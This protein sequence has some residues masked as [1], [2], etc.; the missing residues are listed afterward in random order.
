VAL[1]KTYP[2]FNYKIIENLVSSGVRGIM[3]EGA[4]FGN[5]PVNAV[6]ESTKHHKILLDLFS[7]IS[8]N[9]LLVMTT[10][11][12]NGN[13]ALNVYSTGRIEQKAGILPVPM[14]PET[15]YVK[16][17][18]VLGHTKDVEK[19]KEMMLKD[20]VGE[21]NNRIDPRSF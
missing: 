7:S 1:V 14:T 10:Q 4:G 5:F 11:A 9:V 20:Y 19:A 8:K 12:I 15:A 17:G 13:P 3:L 18:W 21:I 16:L 6:D 2:G